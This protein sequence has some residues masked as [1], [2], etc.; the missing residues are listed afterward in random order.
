MHTRPLV[1]TWLALLVLLGLSAGSALLPLG[2]FNTA[3]GLVI[4]LVKALLVA[5][6]FM[7]LR[8]AHALL[9]IAAITGIVTMALLFILS[10]ADYAT[11]P[12]LPADWQ[13]PKTVAPALGSRSDVERQINASR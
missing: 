13:A 11:R 8:R 6:V 7:R 3:I 2:W 10:G 5:V 1:L 12:Q 4:A 9:R